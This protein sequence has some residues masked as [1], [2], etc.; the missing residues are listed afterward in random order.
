MV[1]TRKIEIFVCEDD[2]DLRKEYY[3]KLYDSR[4][5]AVKV[6][7][8]AVSHLFALDNTMPYLTDEA[9]DIVQFIGVK[10]NSA[11]RQ[12][13]P[14]VVAS[15]VFKGKADMGMVSCVLQNV[16]KM[17]KDD[18][19]K[20][21]W[22]RSLRSYKENM[23]IPYKADRY[24]NLRF[25]EYTNKEG[26]KLDGC[27]F[28]LTGIPFQMR[29]G[30]DNSNNRVI[31][32]RILQQL[33]YNE[34]QEGIEHKLL[35]GEKKIE[36]VNTGYKFCTS[37]IA[38]EKKFDPN[39]NKKMSKIF[40]YLCVDIPKQQ[41]KVDP[42]KILY[43]YLGISNPIKCLVDSQCDDIKSP[44]VRWL[45]IGDAEEF[46][47]RRTQIQAAVRRCQ[48]YCKY[49]KGGKGHMRKLQAIDRFHRKE[50][51]YVETK[52][53]QYSKELVD[54]ALENGCGT[55]YLVNQKPREDKAKLDAERG[56]VL[57]LRN[58]SYF[59]LKQKIDYKCNKY[60]IKM[61]S[62]GKELPEDEDENK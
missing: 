52:L 57:A 58:W 12:N 22:E 3:Q 46:F 45:N 59:G 53:H 14:Y 1:I 9:K 19:K 38:F 20:G 29:F 24:L 10:G 32:Q 30:R 61:K 36:P 43:A 27:F 35:P 41:A 62:L 60:G 44:T 56:D 23:P 13:A 39:S 18:C 16:Q 42:K 6:A 37:S 49:N 51:N 40:L 48:I 55:I 7:N 47:Y 21:M 2:K 8:M 15:E 28:T 33:R 4:N 50:K 26:K 11:T 17:Y 31:V 25:G 54:K 5:V 34:Q